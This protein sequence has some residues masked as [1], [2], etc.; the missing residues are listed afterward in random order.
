[1]WFDKRDFDFSLVLCNLFEQILI[2]QHNLQLKN[3][4]ATLCWLRRQSR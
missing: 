4:L 1:M 2:P 3:S